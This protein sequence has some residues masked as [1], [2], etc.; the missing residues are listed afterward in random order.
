[1]RRLNR[2]RK[3]LRF[4]LSPAAFN[5]AI[6]F[7]SAG[8]S[9]LAYVLVVKGGAVRIPREQDY[10]GFLNPHG[11]FPNRTRSPREWRESILTNGDQ[12]G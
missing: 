11:A 3:A 10:A 12:T 6:V 4:S 1:M 5:P 2:K 8:H 9:P 7:L